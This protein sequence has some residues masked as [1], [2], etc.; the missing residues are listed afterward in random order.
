MEVQSIGESADHRMMSGHRGDSAVGNNT[1][2]F[3]N[4]PFGN[5]DVYVYWGGHY[6]DDVVPDHMAVT[7]GTETYW[8]RRDN[9]TWSGT[10]VQSTATTKAASVDSN[11]VLFEDLSSPSFTLTITPD[12]N[13][14]NRVSPTGIQIIRRVS[15]SAYDEWLSDFPELEESARGRLANP[16]G[17][18][19][20]NLMKFALG[21]S[22][23]ERVNGP[24]VESSIL[25]E[26]EH[27]H[28][29]LSFALRTGA[30]GSAGQG[31]EVDGIRYWVEFSPD[32]VN[33]FRGVD[34][35]EE[36]GSRQENGNGTE[37]V[38]VRVRQPMNGVARQF[39]RLVIEDLE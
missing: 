21:L 17:D 30:T 37:T 35:V 34:D 32:L 8:I 25:E 29:S 28:L 13:G 38:T 27:R 14:R 20:P 11:Y 33:W 5:Y 1:L 10:Y 31:Y 24:L 26:G 19:V 2:T 6:E 12:T 7:L 4:I 39:I 15:L 18:G 9:T 16:S 22:P 23:L 3:E 36:V